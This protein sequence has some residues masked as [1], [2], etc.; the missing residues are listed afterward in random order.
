MLESFM[1]S[2]QQYNSSRGAWEDLL[3][4]WEEKAAALPPPAASPKTIQEQID[5][6]KVMPHVYGNNTD[7]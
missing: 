3:C 5:C 6:I 7:I 1:P 4:G 2:V